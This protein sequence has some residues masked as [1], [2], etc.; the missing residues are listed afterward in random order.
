M[1]KSIRNFRT[2]AG[3]TV[4]WTHDPN[5]FQP[6]YMPPYDRGSWSCGGCRHNGYGE[7]YQASRH[8][9]NCREC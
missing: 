9:E 2:A 6:D 5:A 1:S 7:P 4:T 3:Q 8:A